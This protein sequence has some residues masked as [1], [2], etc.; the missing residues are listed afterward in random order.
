MEPPRPEDGEGQSLRQDLSAIVRGYRAAAGS[1]ADLAAAELRLAA[2]TTVLILALAIAIAL[3]ASSA[4]L[5]LM[6]AIAA[7]LAGAPAWP[8]A[9]AGVAGANLL[10]AL[11]C[12]TWMRA[13]TPNLTFRE[14]R[15]A[16]AGRAPGVEAAQPAANT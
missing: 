13:V 6:L 9:L 5:L 12:W 15:A 8:A 3:F 16:L 4:W 7:L 1:T 10:A 14:L 2:S 11:G